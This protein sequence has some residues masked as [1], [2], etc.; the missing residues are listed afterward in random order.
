MTSA[1]VRLIHQ[2]GRAQ[3]LTVP[4]LLEER[5]NQPHLLRWSKIL[6]YRT[7]GSRMIGSLEQHLDGTFIGSGWE[8]LVFEN[9]ADRQVKK[10]IIDTMGL[11]SAAINGI[12]KIR[13]QA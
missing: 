4:E 7:V 1:K 6:A 8:A 12:R 9:Q 5:R 3:R 13:E 2:A 10:I 11:N